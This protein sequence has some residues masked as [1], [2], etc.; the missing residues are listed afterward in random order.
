[1]YVGA[2][3]TVLATTHILR[4]QSYEWRGQYSNHI[5]SIF[6]SF[7]FFFLKIFFPQIMKSKDLNHV[8]SKWKVADEPAKIWDLK[9]ALSF[10]TIA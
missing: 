5:S 9:S 10:S 3:V 8:L 6:H 2:I 4:V 1:M 7:G